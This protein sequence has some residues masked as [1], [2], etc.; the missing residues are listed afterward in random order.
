MHTYQKIGEIKMIFMGNGEH[1]RTECKN[2]H[3]RLEEGL[4]Q[5]SGSQQWTPPD[6]KFGSPCG[7]TMEEWEEWTEG[8]NEIS[9][10]IMGVIEDIA[11]ALGAKV[12]RVD[13]EMRFIS[14]IEIKRK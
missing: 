5:L 1:S 4:D 7:S 2:L 6:D 3:V 10:K 14:E 12:H 8:Q 11:A 9:N 13:D